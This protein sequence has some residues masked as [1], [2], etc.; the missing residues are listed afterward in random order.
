LYGDT[1]AIDHRGLGSVDGKR[2]LVAEID[3]LGLA[4][5]A[6]SS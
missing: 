5:V 6:A 4:S 2:R 3:D 1:A